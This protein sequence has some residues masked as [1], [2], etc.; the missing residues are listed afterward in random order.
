[1]ADRGLVDALADCLEAMRM[2]KTELDECLERH[3][4]HREELVALLDL[5]RQIPRLPA[6]IAPSPALRERVRRAFGFPGGG[7]GAPAPEP[8]SGPA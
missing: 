4:A 3:H 2:G 6:D 5:A 8:Q 7:N 1:M